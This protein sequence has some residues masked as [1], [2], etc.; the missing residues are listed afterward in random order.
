MKAFILPGSNIL[1][2]N[3]GDAGYDL[4]FNSELYTKDSTLEVTSPLAEVCCYGG[5]LHFSTLNEPSYFRVLINTGVAVQTPHG[6]FGKILDRSS[7]AKKGFYISGGVI[8]NGYR[9]FIH[10]IFNL[11]L[12]AD[13]FRVIAHGD[14]IAQMVILPHNN[15]ELFLVDTIEDLTPTVRG[16]KG[17]GST[18]R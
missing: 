15:T 7:M 6:H 3:N 9:G 5:A 11:I 18:G 4:T 12:G 14:K 2:P 10:I 16:A 17:F 8:D 1:S 13:D